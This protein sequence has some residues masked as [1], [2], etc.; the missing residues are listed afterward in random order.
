MA[1]LNPNTASAI[2]PLKAPPDIQRDWASLGLPNRGWVL[3]TDKEL[4]AL[5]TTQGPAPCVEACTL[6]HALPAGPRAALGT[7]AHCDPAACEEACPAGAVF[8][9]EQGVV[10]VDQ[11][12][13]IGC[14]FCADVCPNDA[15]LFV[16]AYATATP[17]N[18][19]PGYS[20]GQPTGLLPSTVAKC[21][22]CHDHL[23]QGELPVCAG[24]CAMNAIWVGNLDR[25][26]ATN[27]Y[28][29]MRL[30][31]LLEQRPFDIVPPGNRYLC[32]AQ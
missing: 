24:A 26:T 15:L 28:K 1:Y 11:E 17:P 14:R 13:C 6:D 3:I 29:V 25:N 16:D 5:C 8:H 9:T 20:A 23:T 32:L 19:L 7:C 31:D 10:A 30:T 12:L 22:L 27:G 21:T 4:C 18:G 2:L